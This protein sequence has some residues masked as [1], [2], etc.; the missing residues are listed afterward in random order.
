MVGE[1]TPKAP[2]L[3]QDVEIRVDGR[4]PSLNS[5]R[6]W[7]QVAKDNADWKLATEEAATKVREAW[8]STHG[9]RWRT[10]K[11]VLLDVTFLVSTHGRR[12]W[13]NLTSTLKP[14][15]DGIVAAGIIADDSTDVIQRVAFEV[16][17]EKGV[18]ATLFRVRE[19]DDA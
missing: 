12:D 10:M 7:R 6:H 14:E 2:R 13:D 17:Y 18:T 9:L 4:P 16:Q 5:R 3:Y 19:L 8:E 15:L 11:L 1:L